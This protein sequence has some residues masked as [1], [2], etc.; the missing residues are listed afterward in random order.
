MDRYAE[1]VFDNQD[2]DGESFDEI[3]E[4]AF[5]QIGLIIQWWSQV[6][7]TPASAAMAVG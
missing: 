1:C 6:S 3:I 5:E 2:I 7:A 4:R